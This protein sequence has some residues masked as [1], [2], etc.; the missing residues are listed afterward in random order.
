MTKKV[1]GGCC[2]PG[3]P[4]G[5]LVVVVEA[6]PLGREPNSTN[7][8]ATYSSSPLASTLSICTRTFGAGTGGR[9]YGVLSTA[10]MALTSAAQSIVNFA[11]PLERFRASS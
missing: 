3:D 4:G 2:A 11:A 9:A 5:A 7:P 10:L 6:T 1:A 8:L